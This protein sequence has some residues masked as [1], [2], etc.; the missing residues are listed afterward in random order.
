MRSFM[1]WLLPAKERGGE[2]KSGDRCHSQ[3]SRCCVTLSL[4]SNHSEVNI[5]PSIVPLINSHIHSMNYIHTYYVT[6][7]VVDMYLVLQKYNQY[8][9]RY[10]KCL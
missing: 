10:S 8:K 3:S 5:L 9:V 7:T 2:P 4:S 1:V 6:G